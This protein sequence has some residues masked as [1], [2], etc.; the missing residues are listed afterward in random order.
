M[1]SVE[2]LLVLINSG[3]CYISSRFLVVFLKN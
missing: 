1:I 3:L 2:G